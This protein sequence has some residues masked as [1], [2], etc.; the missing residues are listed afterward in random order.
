MV[1]TIGIFRSAGGAQQ[2]LQRCLSP[3]NHRST[4]AVFTSRWRSR[5]GRDSERLGLPTVMLGMVTVM[6]AIRIIPGVCRGSASITDGLPPRDGRTGARTLRTTPIGV[7]ACWIC[8]SLRKTVS[9]LSACCAVLTASTTGRIDRSRKTTSSSSSSVSRRM[10]NDL[11][12]TSI[13]AV[14]VQAATR[15]G[16][17]ATATA[18]WQVASTILPADVARRGRKLAVD[19]TIGSLRAGIWL[20]PTVPGI[21][22]QRASKRLGWSFGHRLVDKVQAS[23]EVAMITKDG[24]A[25]AV[26]LSA[27]EFDS[28]A[29]TTGRVT[30]RS[31]VS[32]I[33]FVEQIEAEHVAKLG[34]LGA[35][36]LGVRRQRVAP[37][38]GHQEHPGCSRLPENVPRLGRLQARVDSREGQA[39]QRS[40]VLELRPLQRNRRSS[41]PTPDGVPARRCQTVTTLMSSRIPSRNRK[42][43]MSSR[44]TVP[45]SKRELL[46]V[47]VSQGISLIVMIMSG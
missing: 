47:P 19:V 38:L 23:G 30:L 13:G 12:A 29:P 31:P 42:A 2:Q 26:L 33:S 35:D 39:G 22:R 6:N 44:V 28:I 34:Q 10:L 14:T 25:R 17:P 27:G 4:A 24:V 7:R 3:A 40:A 21:V 18:F 37:D 11:L 45:V 41:C 15:T 16:T 1:R 32:A 8:S 9:K 5:A 46:E 36:R 20:T 43:L